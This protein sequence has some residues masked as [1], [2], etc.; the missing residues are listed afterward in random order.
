MVNFSHGRLLKHGKSL[1]DQWVTS[2]KASKFLFAL[3]RT[4]NFSMFLQ[5]IHHDPK[6]SANFFGIFLSLSYAQGYEKM[7]PILLGSDMKAFRNFLKMSRNCAKK[8]NKTKTKLETIDMGTIGDFVAILASLC[9]L[10]TCSKKVFDFVSKVSKNFTL[11]RLRSPKNSFQD[12]AFESIIQ[13]K[14]NF[15]CYSNLAVNACLKLI[16]S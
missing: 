9:P 4:P 12:F 14:H 11:V 1:L 8:I 5:K 13:L 16:R 3:G 2:E 10:G 6:V 15:F 7:V